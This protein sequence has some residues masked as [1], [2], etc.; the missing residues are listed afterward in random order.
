V[1]FS[2]L[3][4]PEQRVLGCLIEKRWTTPDQYPLSLNALRLAC[5]Q[6][7]NRDPV[8]HYDEHTV[9]EAAQRLS[10]YGLARLASGHSSRAIKYRHLA[11][12]AL[13][14]GREELAVLCV[15]LLRGAQTAPELRTRTERLHPFANP[16]DV[17]RVLGRLA[18]REPPL[19][20]RLTPGLGQREARWLQLLEAGA[21]E[22][23][24]H[25]S[26]APVATGRG[27][28]RLDELEGRV[29][30]VEA[31]L[32]SLLERLGEVGEQVVDGL[33]PDRKP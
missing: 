21:A 14:L 16:Q 27:S 19:V 2:E 6:S 25:I 7:T 11:E 32:A 28:S 5:N 29:S 3:T 4:A 18:E 30:A 17:E 23:A 8:T 20:L 10:K 9:R 13:A 12:E 33:D 31:T 24:A 22:R 15:L 1:H 26:D